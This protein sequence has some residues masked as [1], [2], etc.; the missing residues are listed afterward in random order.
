M[1]ASGTAIVAPVTEAEAQL[2][3]SPELPHSPDLGPVD[4]FSGTFLAATTAAIYVCKYRDTFRF[5]R[6]LNDPGDPLSG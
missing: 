5:S 6:T 3:S 1:S 4:V 2:G